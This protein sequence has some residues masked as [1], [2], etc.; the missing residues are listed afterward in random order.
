MRV[1]KGVKSIGEYL[2][3]DSFIWAICG[4]LELEPLAVSVSPY[5]WYDSLWLA[6][7]LAV[8]STTAA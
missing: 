4:D 1:Q 7:R 2:K 8:V 6:S 3:I 5:G